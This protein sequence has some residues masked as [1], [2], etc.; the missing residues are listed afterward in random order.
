MFFILFLVYILYQSAYHTLVLNCCDRVRILQ[1]Q[2]QSS[3]E[4][5]ND[6]FLVRVFPGVPEE[7]NAADWK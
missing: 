1:N 5:G 2:P 7:C 3:I 4:H 6:A